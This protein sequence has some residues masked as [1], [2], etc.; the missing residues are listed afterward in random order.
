MREVGKA[1]RHLR[2][3]SSAAAAYTIT[4]GLAP[5]ILPIADNGLSPEYGPLSARQFWVPL[6]PELLAAAGE[7]QIG[8]QWQQQAP[9]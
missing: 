2:R 1:S 6:P 8:L 9:L 3:R 5:P 7:E 4:P